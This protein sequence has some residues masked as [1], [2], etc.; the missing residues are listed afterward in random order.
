MRANNS[1]E[2][3]GLNVSSATNQKNVALFASTENPKTSKKSEKSGLRIKKIASAFSILA[4]T[5]KRELTVKL[6]KTPAVLS[7]AKL[8]DSKKQLMSVKINNVA[9]KNE[10]KSTATRFAA[11]NR[12]IIDQEKAQLSQQMTDR[13]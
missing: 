12:S 9:A 4:A 10:A 8:S 6:R 2:N 3:F 5:A 7:K 11:K 1:T 13:C